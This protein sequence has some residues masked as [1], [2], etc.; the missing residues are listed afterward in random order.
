MW[1]SVCVC[2]FMHNSEDKVKEST[3]VCSRWSTWSSTGGRD[4][5][6]LQT[7]SA[8]ASVKGHRSLHQQSLERTGADWRG[9]DRTKRG[10]PVE[11][12]THP[13]NVGQQFA[14]TK[15]TATRRQP[16]NHL[17]TLLLALHPHAWHEMAREGPK[18]AVL[19]TLIVCKYVRW[20]T[21]HWLG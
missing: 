9:E 17:T 4:C 18:R 1:V 5:W 3:Q 21:M 2:V 6:K 14:V 15:G 10:G 7:E 16:G 19:Q 11:K 8:K 13:K 12:V 20:G